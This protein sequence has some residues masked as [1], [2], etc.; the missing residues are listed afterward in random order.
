MPKI[1]RAA[2]LPPPPENVGPYN[3]S[4]SYQIIPQMH[5]ECVADIALSNALYTIS[6]LYSIPEKNRI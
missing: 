5:V 6:M 2:K 1:F 4:L 3:F